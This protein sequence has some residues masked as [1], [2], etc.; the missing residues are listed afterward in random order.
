[1]HFNHVFPPGERERALDIYKCY[2]HLM[3]I[4]N[5][6]VFFF[7]F[8]LNLLF[9]SEN[10]SHIQGIIFCSTQSSNTEEARSIKISIGM[11]KTPNLW[12]YCLILYRFCRHTWA[13]SLVGWLRITCG[14]S[15][16]VPGACPAPPCLSSLTLLKMWVKPSADAGLL[17]SHSPNLGTAAPLSGC[18][19]RMLK[20][21]IICGMK[22]S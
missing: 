17:T 6:F 2:T 11:V 12:I 15:L 7:L 9:C 3:I 4:H 5:A 8:F 1:M 14:L 20:S 10:N 19:I 22:I 13:L 18:H 21:E 16:G